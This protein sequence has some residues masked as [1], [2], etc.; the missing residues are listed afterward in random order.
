MP[1][2]R[3]EPSD[4]E[5]EIDSIPE[6]EELQAVDENQPE[7]SV[8]GMV[9]RI[10]DHSHDQAVAKQPAEPQKAVKKYAAICLWNFGAESP[11]S[12]FIPHG[13]DPLEDLITTASIATRSD[14]PQAARTPSH[15]CTPVRKLC[16]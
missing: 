9:D 5:K 1:P 7:I 6:L 16:V 3:K 13:K 11:T 4:K 2:R 15:L 12:P 14:S 8:Q 10:E